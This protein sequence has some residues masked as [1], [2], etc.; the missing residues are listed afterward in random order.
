MKA[1]FKLH[2]PHYTTLQ[3]G[4]YLMHPCNRDPQSIRI[5]ET[6]LQSQPQLPR[7]LCGAAA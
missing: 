4:Q 1:E 6:V 7:G 2:G 3:Y 5:A